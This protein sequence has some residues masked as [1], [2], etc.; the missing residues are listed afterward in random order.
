MQDSIVLCGEIFIIDLATKT[1]QLGSDIPYSVVYAGDTG[2]IEIIF[3]NAT[4]PNTIALVPVGNQIK[5]VI[6]DARQAQSTFTRL[7]F[8]NGH[9]SQYFKPFSERI[10]ILN[11]KVS[12]WTVDWEGKETI[13]VES[14]ANNPINSYFKAQ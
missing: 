9:G 11:E 2:L 8:F 10:T 13:I 1:A 12:V 3:E 7:F 5:A 14:V 6:M 4:S